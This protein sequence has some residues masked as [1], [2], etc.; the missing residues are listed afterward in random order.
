[1]IHL[2][3]KGA[4]FLPHTQKDYV[5][6]P[7]GAAQVDFNQAYDVEQAFTSLPLHD[8]GNSESCVSHAW[9]YYHEMLRFI[10]FGTLPQFSRHDLYSR[11]FIAPEGGAF[12]KDG[13]SVICTYGQSLAS[14]DPDI[15]PATEPTMRLPGTISAEPKGLERSYGMLPAADINSIAAA[16][17]IYGGV[18]FGVTGSDAGWQD[19]HYP[20]APRTGEPT[21]G[22]ALFCKGYKMI[23][24]K[25]V[26]VCKTSWNISPQEH[27][28][29]EDYFAS[30][31][32]FNA[33][34][35]TPKGQSM[36]SNNIL[37]GTNKDV[38]GKFQE[39]GFYSPAISQDGLKNL[40]LERGIQLPVMADGTLDFVQMQ[41]LAAE[42]IKK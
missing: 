26:I 40:A 38:S 16:I 18:V 32:T 12:I 2:F 7:F 39:F 31:N 14:I 42:L 23:N 5:A 27:Y 25:R 8:Q 37:V 1:M 20:R 13:G 41:T 19:I 30:G 21:W 11:I 35:L 29:D 17:K 15:L 36:A 3:G 4:R 28:I 33:W 6:L 24:G 9:S 10:E 22:H 34:T